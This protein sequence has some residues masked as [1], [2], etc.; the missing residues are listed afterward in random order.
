MRYRHRIAVRIGVNTGEV[1]GRGGEMFASGDAVVLGDAVNVAARLEQ[2]AAPGEVLIGEPTYRLVRDAVVVEPIEPSRRRG[3]RSR[4]RLTGCS[5]S[6]APGRSPRRAQGRALVG[7]ERGARRC[8]SRSSRR[9]LPGA[10]PARDRRRRAGCREVA[11][12]GRARRADRRARARRARRLPLLR[13]GDHLLGD[14]R[15]V[16]ELAGIRDERLGRGGAS[17]RAPARR[18]RAA[19][20]A[21]EGGSTAEETRRGDRSGSWPRPPPSSRSS[22]VVDDIQWAEPA[23]LDLLARLPAAI[24]G[25][26]VLVSASR[27]PSCSSAAR[28]GR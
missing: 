25:A 16:R 5:R 28:T 15:V 14:R 9:S 27:G 11:A 4:S 8:S 6:S 2:A 23:L 10:L 1:V 3:S 24:A 18:D 12:G 26:P 20:R 22:C 17:A 13:R 7:R 21:R 19:A